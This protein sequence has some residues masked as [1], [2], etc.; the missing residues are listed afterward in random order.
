MI[1]KSPLGID[2]FDV[3][4]CTVALVFGDTKERF[5]NVANKILF[6]EDYFF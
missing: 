5:E 2:T 3:L 1:E 6:D 4:L